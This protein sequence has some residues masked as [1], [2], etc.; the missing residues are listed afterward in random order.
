MSARVRPE[1]T[2]VRPPLAAVRLPLVPDAALAVD[3]A[4]SPAGDRIALAIPG[5][6][7]ARGRGQVYEL[8][9]AASAGPC[10]AVTTTVL[11]APGQ[12]VAVGWGAD[13]TLFAQT[14]AP[15]ALVAL[16]R[17]ARLVQLGRQENSVALGDP[18]P[19]HPG[20]RLFHSNPTGLLTCA[21][22]HP[23]G[24]DDG[25][26]W[27]FAAG[28][29]RTPYLRGGLLG[30]EPFHWSGDLRDFRALVA[31]VMVNGLRA[32][33]PDDVAL[34]SLGW[35]LHRLPAHPSPR[36]D[37]AVRARGEALFRSAEV[38]CATCHAGPRYT[39]NAS[40]DL[41]T[42]GP[43]QV[44]TL[45]GLAWRAPYMHNGCAATLRGRFDRAC[46]GVDHGRYEGLDE[47]SLQDLIV[48]LESL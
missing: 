32:P 21:S 42:G 31:E 20:H 30:S 9:S 38:G 14:R 17:G 12:V 47:G 23:E 13:G 34:R 45:L 41:Q 26:T 2:L 39:N 28:P 5:N 29:R 18:L 16:S 4:A 35:W 11:S 33:A 46:G 6:V 44:P 8:A 3:L 22:C 1:V 27:A 24:D 25:H 7:G 37:A 48:Y 36:V 15:A 19:E 40:V 43:M 10:L